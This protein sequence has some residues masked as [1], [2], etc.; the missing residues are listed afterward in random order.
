M[1]ICVYECLQPV[2]ILFPAKS[3]G[4]K[5]TDRASFKLQCNETEL[6]YI[7]TSTL[8]RSNT[9]CAKR[10]CCPSHTACTVFASLKHVQQLKDSCDG[11]QECQVKVARGY[12]RYHYKG[13]ARMHRGRRTDY[14]SVN[15][16][17]IN[18]PPGK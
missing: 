15:Y 17:C 8:G 4:C 13:S 18:N 14:E 5:Y 12:C 16:F 7:T 11:K 3:S 9:S 6:I 2:C 10:K 1:Y